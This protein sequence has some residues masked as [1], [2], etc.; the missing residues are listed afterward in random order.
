[1][2]FPF[3]GAEELKQRILYS[4][5]LLNDSEALIARLHLQVPNFFEK[6]ENH[7]EIED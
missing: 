5:D 1:M 6:F 2:T 3:R 4:T 7:L